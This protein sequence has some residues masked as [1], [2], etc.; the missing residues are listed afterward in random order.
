MIRC[1]EA[2]LTQDH[3]SFEVLVI[4]NC[5]TD[6]TAEAVKE[7]AS[8]AP[9]PVH[10]VVEA[11]SLG[12]VRNVATKLANGEVIAFTDSDCAPAPGWLAAGVAALESDPRVGIVQGRTLPDADHLGPWPNTQQITGPSL[13]FECCNIF[14]RLDALRA[15]D[16]FDEEMVLFGEDTAAGWSVMRQGWARLF[17]PDALVHH[18]V[19][20]PGLAWHLRRALRYETFPALVRK[21]PEM[22]DDL[23][24]HRWFLSRRYA[25]FLGAVVGIALAL[26]WRPALLLALPY[27]WW[28]RPAKPRWPYVRGQLEGTLY[29]AAGFTGLVRGSIRHRS[30]VL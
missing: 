9:V 20:Y 5:S 25:A 13:H 4:D 28:R 19:T 21:Y 6:G 24:W 7:R 16:G 30:V 11:G 29:D 8:T 10:V 15:S 18:D 3:P 12:H 14:Y 17:E 22:R 1:L 27:A 2:I 23:F 26:R